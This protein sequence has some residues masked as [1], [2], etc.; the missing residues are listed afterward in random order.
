MKRIT[1]FVI[2]AL[3]AFAGLLSS[4]VQASPSEQPET[5]GE[6]GPGEILA[7]LPLLRNCQYLLLDAFGDPS[8]GWPVGDFGNVE[9][10]YFNNEYRILITESNWWGAAHQGLVLT[11]YLISADVRRTNLN[12]GRAGLIFEIAGDWSSFYTYEIDHE[13]NYVL[14]RYTGTWTPL[15]F[16]FSDSLKTGTLSNNLA[17]ERNGNVIN[18]FANE[19]LID[20][21]FDGTL[22]GARFTGV[23]GVNFTGG[24][25][26]IRYDN[27]TA[28]PIGCGL[29]Q[30]VPVLPNP[31]PSAPDGSAPVRFYGTELE[32]P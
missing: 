4:R 17:V 10:Q 12:S 18:L 9:Y 30:E 28:L 23:F 6:E 21:A 11:D 22:Q 16:G 25:Q 2:L 31:E 26:D 29:S 8:S 24:N 27:F 5:A 1:A 3:F 13:G 7:Y 19:V 14:W 15:T 20:G 32:R